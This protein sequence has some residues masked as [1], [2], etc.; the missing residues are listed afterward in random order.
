[1]A[2]Y[3]KVITLNQGFSTSTI[4]VLIIIVGYLVAPMPSAH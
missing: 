3:F 2:E 4:G 1:M